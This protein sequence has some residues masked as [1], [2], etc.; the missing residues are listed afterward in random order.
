[1]SDHEPV[2]DDLTIRRLSPGDESL[3]MQAAHLFDE[4]PQLLW[5]AEFL[6]GA[7]HHLLIA[8]R[9]NRAAG[10]VSAVEMTHP[11]KGIE[12]F[13]YELSVAPEDRRQGVAKALLRELTAIA[14]QR[15][16]YDMWVLTDRDNVAA[17]A[18]Y[19]SSGATEESDHVMLTWPLS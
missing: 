15:G 17:L 7:T 19:R 3:V 5:A 11:D 12:M 1:M 4:P 18:A 13:L 14:K 2:A 8:Y 10:F 16:C 6:D 9:S